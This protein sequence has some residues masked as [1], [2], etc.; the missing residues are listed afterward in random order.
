MAGNK[1]FMWFLRLM[2][3]S[4]SKRKSRLFLALFALSIS[5]CVLSVF[6]TLYY[7]ISLKMNKELR[8][9]GANLILSPRDKDKRDYITET[10]LKGI[11][12]SLDKTNLAG[13]APY[14]FSVAELNS[15]SI[16]LAGTWFDQVKKVSPYWE[17]KGEWINS[18]D[19]HNSVLVG[20]EA[21]RKIGLK[22]GDRIRLSEAVTSL[23][24]EVVIKGI[25]KTGGQE[26]NQVFAN[27][28][29]AQKLCKRENQINTASLSIIGQ[30]EQLEQISKNIENNYKDVSVDLIRRISRS[31]GAVIHKIKLL[32]LLVTIVTLF[33]TLLCVGATMT[34]M[35]LE[36]SKEIGLK[37]AL[38]A[39][40]PDIL[41]EFLIESAFAGIGAGLLG[42]LAGFVLV[43]FIGRSVFESA[44]SFRPAVIPVTIAV[45][46]TVSF[47]AS[48]LPIKMALGIEPATVLKGE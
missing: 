45:S 16:V 2:G 7:D 13:C 38:G 18:R 6:L 25:I 41:M 44:V 40:N 11:I 22:I 8:A 28:S 9:Y 14:L 33:S 42:Y 29:L 46:I 3:K 48:L 20:Y 27:L 12:Q 21:A 1:K 36:R 26:E 43:Q 4:L 10:D 34:A 37:K 39:R 35:T 19:D 17:I 5:G 15:R 30:G 24:A 32:L 23:P 31:E 47:L